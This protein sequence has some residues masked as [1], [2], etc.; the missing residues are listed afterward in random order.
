MLI[1]CMICQTFEVSRKRIVSKSL[2]IY[3]ELV[4]EKINVRRKTSK[5]NTNKMTSR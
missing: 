3:V 4:L 5:K 2:R 1:M